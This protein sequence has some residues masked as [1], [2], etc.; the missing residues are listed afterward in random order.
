MDVTTPSTG[1]RHRLKG[2][3]ALCCYLLWAHDLLAAGLPPAPSAMEA[4]ADSPLYLELVINQVSN[5]GAVAVEQREGHYWVAAA[6]LRSAG[7]KLPAVPAEVDLT[8]LAGLHTEYDPLG[9]RLLLTVPPDWLPTQRLGQRDLYART[10]ALSSFGALVN[11]DLYLNDA[12]VDA[13]YVAAWSE[14][15][16]F[17][18]WGTLANTG[19]F[20]RT[21]SGPA[22]SL[23]GTGYR[24]YDTTWRYSDDDRLLTYEVGD[25]VSGALPWNSSVRLG[26]LQVS[27]DFSVRPDLVTY[28]LPQFAG[29]VAVPSSMDLFINGYK[30][31]SADLQPGPYTV[32]SIPFINGAGE[33]EVLTT[34]ALGRQVSTTMPFYVTSTL[35]QKGLSDYSVAI[36]SLRRDYAIRDFAYHSLVT[37]NSL[38]YGLSDTL[39]L[40]SHLE[41]AD[42]FLQGGVGS[43]LQLGNAG[44]LNASLSQSR[45]EDEQ[46]QQLGLGY[47]YS[48]ARYTLSYQ[49]QER[50]HRYVDLAVLDSASSL[51]QSSEQIL[52]NLNLEHWGSLGLGYFKVLAADT[53]RT[54]LLNLTWSKSLW[55]STSVYLSA[56]R[57]LSDRSW[58]LQ[59]QLV[60]AFD[61]HG[62]LSMSNV[63]SNQGDNQ[64]QL[65]YSHAVPSEGGLGFNV[66]VARGDGA[67]YR[68][69]DLTWRLQSVQLQAGVYGRDDASTRW[70]DASGALVWMDQQ[71]FAA[72]RIDDA[73]VVVSTGG[74]ADIP[75]RYENQLIGQTDDH[76][77]LLVPW[78]SG[79]YRGKY[80]IDPLNLPTSVQS[81][82]VEQ[83]IA[84]RR[85]SGYLLTFPLNRIFA[86]SVVLVDAQQRV[87]PL[88]SRVLHEQS[89]AQAIVG[90]DGL[91]YLDQLQAYNTV[92]VTLA[93][94]RTCQAQFPLDLQ[95]T[96]VAFIGPLVCQ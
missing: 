27:R 94:A 59:A 60:L 47:Q 7:L 48:T 57:D 96:Q 22:N 11:Y 25:L 80:E 39:T 90:W 16:L 76:G 15:R 81:P 9:Q 36:G 62:S 33:A 52:L 69:A 1:T 55:R 44:V 95:Q 51:S 21:L 53:S 30:T 10:P 38:R 26:G 8:T 49:R 70:A 88:G 34:D 92:R 37:A 14:L 32:T 63:R 85:N 89:G 73:F 67:D 29:E 71:V 50:R 54:R 61:Q 78:S 6:V 41:A 77:H 84:V 45:W 40:E 65:N 66:G 13:R 79:Y 28:P 20:R 93:D 72:N 46:G 75:V 82:I 64:Q 2:V 91:V 87:L 23:L 24:R 4:V 56:S 83:R 31:S 18:S 3:I 42:A 43:S 68:Q 12:D 19:Q 74:F 86:A 5:G 58:A 35:L 17:D